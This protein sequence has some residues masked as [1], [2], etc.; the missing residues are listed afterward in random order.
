MRRQKRLRGRPQGAEVLFV[1]V[2]ETKI[3][4]PI[5]RFAS[6]YCRT[7]YELDLSTLN[8]IVLQTW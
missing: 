1:M 3:S 6:V 7:E 2:S 8:A 5:A 4:Q